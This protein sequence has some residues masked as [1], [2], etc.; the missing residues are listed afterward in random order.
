[1]ADLRR[2]VEKALGM[3]PQLTRLF[4]EEVEL[5]SRFDAKI[6]QCGLSDSCVLTAVT[7]ASEQFMP[8]K[9]EQREQPIPKRL[10]L[11][12]LVGHDAMSTC[13]DFRDMCTGDMVTVRLIDYFDEDEMAGRIYLLQQLNHENLLKLVDVLPPA[14]PDFKNFCFIVEHMETDLG[15]VLRSIANI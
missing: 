5:A 10:Q 11:E 13:Y 7:M 9:L 4:R 6:L 12:R 8:V 1:M 3:P 14:T 2:S 15:Q